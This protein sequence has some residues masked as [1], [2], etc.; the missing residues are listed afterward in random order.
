MVLPPAIPYH[1]LI[2]TGQIGVGR[3]TV[4]RLIA[5]KFGA[6]FLDLDTELQLR[7]GMPAEEIRQ[8]F[9]E[10]RLR[11]L[12]DKLCSEI[13]LRRSAVM[14]VSGP[15]LMDPNNRSRLLNS[16]PILILTC[17]L[18]EIL[19]RLHASQ[20]ARFHDP[21]V[22]STALYQIRREQQILQVE[23]LPTL[24]TTALSIDEVAEHASR[25]WREH[26]IL[27]N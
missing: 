27:N 23:G 24:D 17:D 25:F 8:L 22:R 5:R 6:V 7:E 13:S 1:N 16:G 18:N 9:G 20:G 3:V 14:S 26:D 15:T 21:K 2:L 19:R 10:Q 12:E 11:G 4:G